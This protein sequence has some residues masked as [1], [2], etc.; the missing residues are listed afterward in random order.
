[1]ISL[2]TAIGKGALVVALTTGCDSTSGRET[3]VNLAITATTRAGGA[4]ASFVTEDGWQ[5]QLT[6]AAIAIGPV[7]LFENPPPLAQ[8]LPWWRPD[9]WLLPMAHAHAGDQHFNGGAVLAEYVDQLRYDCLS[10]PASLG[11]TPATVGTARAFSLRLD[12]PRLKSG[13]VDLTHGHHAWVAGTATREGETIAFEGGLDIDAAGTLRRVDG[14]PTEAPLDEGGTFTL[15]VHPDA[16]L[17]GADFASLPAS[18][19]AGQ[20][21]RITASTQPGAVWFLGARGRQG[22][23]GRYEPA[24]P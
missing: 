13:E 5:V 15:V 4:P 11:S 7:Y 1:V 6:E 10:G 18:M 2:R 8:R 9:G 23:A 12:P 22:Y 20:P 14:L 16:W 3:V 21:R 24:T 19:E 17:E